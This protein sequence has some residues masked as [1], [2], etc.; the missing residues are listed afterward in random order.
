MIAKKYSEPSVENTVKL[1]M[2]CKHMLSARE[3][4][5]SALKDLHEFEMIIKQIRR[6]VNK[7]I[8]VTPDDELLQ[9]IE[10]KAL[11]RLPQLSEEVLAKIVQMRDKFK[12]FIKMV[13][14]TSK[15]HKVTNV[16]AYKRRDALK[17][18]IREYEGIRRLVQVVDIK[19]CPIVKI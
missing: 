11:E 1:L 4:S 16:M 9:A 6:Q 13:A 8:D 12:L 15:G 17:F 14:T 18:V 5:F 2:R 10:K 7:A 19:L 3:I